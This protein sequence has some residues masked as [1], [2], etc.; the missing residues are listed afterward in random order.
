[1]NIIINTIKN[2]P[3]YLAGYPLNPLSHCLTSSTTNNLFCCSRLPLYSSPPFPFPFPQSHPFQ[4][5]SFA[6]LFPPAV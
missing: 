2:G 1:M 4:Q 6:Y 3:R 5:P